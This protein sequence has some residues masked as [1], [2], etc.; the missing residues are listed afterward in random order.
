MTPGGF[1]EALLARIED[2]SL[3]ASAPPQQRWIDGWLVRTSPG[4]AQRARSINAVAPGRLSLNE[5]LALAHDVYREAGLPMLVR[6]TPFS[7]PPDLDVRLGAMGWLADE[8]THVLV[9]TQDIRGLTPKALAPGLVWQV[10]DGHAFAAA[11]GALRGSTPAQQAAHAQRLTHSPVP[12][13][14]FAVRRGADGPVLCCGQFAREGR[15]VGLYDVF[16]HPA[17]RGEGLAAALCERLLA[18]AARE[19]ATTAYLQVDSANAAALAVYRRLGFV[20]G[21]DYHY[22]REPGAAA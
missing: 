11:I 14:G 17:S 13:R 20:H 1:D 15:W 12:Y 9:G 6:I 2:A 18:A 19:G 4:K 22:R 21:Y 7:M 3:N 10:L 8:P 5:K 16:T